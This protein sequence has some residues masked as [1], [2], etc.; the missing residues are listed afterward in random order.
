MNPDDFSKNFNKLFDDLLIENKEKDSSGKDKTIAGIKGIP[1]G[2][3]AMGIFYN[4]KLIKSVPRLWSDIS[5]NNTIVS[6]DTPSDSET[7][8]TDTASDYTDIML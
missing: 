1:L 4:W 6:T 5:G 7:P 8:I 2:Y 3:Q